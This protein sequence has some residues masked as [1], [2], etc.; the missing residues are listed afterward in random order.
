M[1]YIGL[2]FPFWVW[3]W[4]MGLHIEGSEIVVINKQVWGPVPDTDCPELAIIPPP[5]V[6]V[7]ITRCF[8][9]H[10]AWCSICKMTRT[11]N[12]LLNFSWNFCP[13]LYLDGGPLTDTSLSTR[14]NILLWTFLKIAFSFKCRWLCYRI[15]LRSD[16]CRV[17]SCRL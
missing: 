6:M 1:I 3:L 15:I 8:Q 5:H 2:V 16:L 13:Y 14:P 17:V 11:L 10:P 4:V 7:I 12:I 9:H